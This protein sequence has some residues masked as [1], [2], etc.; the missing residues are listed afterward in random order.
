MKPNRKLVLVILSLFL[1]FAIFLSILLLNK[2]T[3]DTSH[4]NEDIKNNDSPTVPINNGDEDEVSNPEEQVVHPEDNH[5]HNEL[6]P[7]VFKEGKTTGSYNLTN[8]LSIQGSNFPDFNRTIV[9]SQDG[10]VYVFN[11]KERSITYY[12][13]IELL[14][15]TVADNVNQAKYIQDNKMILFEQ[16][17]SKGYTLYLYDYQLNKNGFE[18]IATLESPA[19]DFGL[20]GEFVYYSV[21]E[22]PNKYM[23]QPIP[24]SSTD[25]QLIGFNQVDASN[26][27]PDYSDGFFSYNQP[28]ATFYKYKPGHKPEEYVS[29][30]DLFKEKHLFMLS[31]NPFASDRFIYLSLFSDSEGMGIGTYTLINGTL[32]PDLIDVLDVKWIDRESIIYTKASLTE[33]LYLYNFRTKEKHLIANQVDTFAFDDKSHSIYYLEYGNSELNK[34][35]INKKA[36]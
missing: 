11:E 10:Y 31:V 17:N 2:G 5:E 21:S 18:E 34:I 3:E 8:P 20:T 6:P 26:L 35:Q 19:I 28:N 9:S 12:N 24:T 27:V 30:P 14:T 29:F 25:N 23:Y 22:Q 15:Y 1:L 36:N 13:P 32:S 7:T 4:L 16:K 33:D